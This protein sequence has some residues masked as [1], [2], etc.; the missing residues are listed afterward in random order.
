MGDPRVTV[1]ISDVSVRSGDTR[2][3]EEVSF[4]CF[5]GE[6]TVIYGPS[7]AG[8]S[9]L[10]RAVNGLCPLTG[11]CISVLS[12]R[13]PGRSRREARAVWRQTGTVLQ[14]VA[15]FETKTALENVVLALRTVGLDRRTAREEA[16]GWLERLGLGDKLDA[17]PSRLSGGQRQRVALARA[18][19]VRPRVLLLDEPTSALDRATAQTVLAIVKELVEGG[20]TV[21]MSSH[22]TDEVAEMCHQRVGLQNGRVSAIER[23]VTTGERTRQEM[24]AQ[25]TIPESVPSM[26][27][28]E[29]HPITGLIRKY[30]GR[31]NTG[32]E[33]LG[34]GFLGHPERPAEN[35][36]TPNLQ[37]G[38]NILKGTDHG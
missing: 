26:L 31:S 3:L 20:T 17:Y 10:L 16:G 13:L 24:H 14:E 1:G 12:T 6:W 37:E 34:D 4:D 22:R 5:E 33:P 32:T 30:S 38:T 25:R 18:F 21:V 23:L 19:A 9:T 28:R 29:R 15:L 36:A 35:S 11:G 27:Q 2:I 7:G 8:K